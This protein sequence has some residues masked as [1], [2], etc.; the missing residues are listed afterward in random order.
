MNGAEVVGWALFGGLVAEL[1]S[2]FEL[3]H[4]G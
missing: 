3:R 4:K 2:V 1:L